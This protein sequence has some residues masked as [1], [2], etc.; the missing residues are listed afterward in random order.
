MQRTLIA[1]GLLATTVPAW[2][3]HV[4]EPAPQVL[5]SMIVKGSITVSPQGYVTGYRLNRPGRL[6]PYVVKLLNRAIPKWRFA[7]NVHHG[8]PIIVKTRMSIR[9]VAKPLPNH[10][11]SIA[12]DQANFGVPGA[13]R[14]L[15]VRFKGKEKHPAYPV[16]PRMNHVGG[17]VYVLARI[18]R[19]GHVTKAAV[20]QVDLDVRTSPNV[21]TA[22]RRDFAR[23]TLRAV[24]R[25]TFAI[26]SKGK[27]ASKTDWTVIIPVQYS[28]AYYSHMDTYGK[29]HPYIPGP[30]HYIPWMQDS[31]LAAH[32]R[33]PL[34]DEP[35]MLG[36][37]IKMINTPQG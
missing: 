26:P 5:A 30:T 32:T 19:E 36:V 34:G 31:K 23:T 27:Q 7:P 6:P 4:P 17:T 11:Y 12:I 1:I 21:M 18:N 3:A 22:W 16:E 10:Q 33:P 14:N 9:M 8:Q 13:K 24:R 25:W 29:W 15:Q 35:Q 20:K 2:S 37:G 28:M